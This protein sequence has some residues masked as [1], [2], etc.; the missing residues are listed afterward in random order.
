MRRI[1][2]LA[3]L[4]ALLA[5]SALAGPVTP[6]PVVA[7]ERA[8]AADGYT[9]GFKASFLKHSAPTAIVIQP[10][11]VNAHESLAKAPDGK[12]DDPKLEWW[13]VWAG[14]AKSGDLGFTTGPCALAG[15]RRGH[16]FTV[17][18][19]Q[20]NGDWKWLFDGGTGS[21]ASG[22]PGPGGPVGFL[23]VSDVPA[24]DS[25]E[26]LAEVFAVEEALATVALTDLKAG[27]LTVY[28]CDGRMQGS[29]LPPAEDCEAAAA[30]MATR[31]ATA[32]LKTLGGEASEAGDL[33]WTYGVM[34]WSG[35]GGE[36]KGHYVRVWQRRAEGWRIVFDELLVPPPPRPN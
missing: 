13:P 10:E 25:G 15:Q 20:M 11:P 17:W 34:D 8:F 36:T 3:A 9:M 24:M 21:D 1:A 30:E 14:M 31:P 35:I 32:R 4:P 33:V 5:T 29:A 26:A 6:A 22:A 19:K 18:K 2:T 23:T 16:Y 7:A 27:F 12:P 28:A